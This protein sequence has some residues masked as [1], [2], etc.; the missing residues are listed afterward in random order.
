MNYE[1]LVEALPNTALDT[2]PSNS[3]AEQNSTS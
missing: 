3:S 2:T 1:N